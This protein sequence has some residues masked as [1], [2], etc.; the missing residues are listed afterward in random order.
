MFFVGA[1]GAIAVSRTRTSGV[2]LASASC[3]ACVAS[4]KVRIERGCNV[5]ATAQ[6]FLFDG[7]LRNLLEV[8]RLTRDPDAVILLANAQAGQR[9]P[10]PVAESFPFFSEFSCAMSDFTTGFSSVRL[11][12]CSASFARVV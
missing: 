10:W 9:G 5:A 12:L 1:S 2:A 6:L 8:F 3:A 7:A 11:T 4:L